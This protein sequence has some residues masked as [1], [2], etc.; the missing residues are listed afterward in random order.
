MKAIAKFFLLFVACIIPLTIS[1]SQ[2][3]H[4]QERTVT[5]VRAIAKPHEYNGPCPVAIELA[6]TI[7]VSHHPVRVD[8]QWERSDGAVGPRQSVVIRSAGQGVYTT[9]QLGRRRGAFDGWERLR[10]LAPTG[11]TSNEAQFHVYCE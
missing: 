10:V 5:E 6:A 11:I 9:W 4:S 7:F 8:Y 3:L 1:T 2:E